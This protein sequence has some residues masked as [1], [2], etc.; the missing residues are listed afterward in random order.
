MPA[1]KTNK[2][3]SLFKAKTRVKHLASKATGKV[4]NAIFL[5][6]EKKAKERIRNRLIQQKRL[7]SFDDYAVRRHMLTKIKKGFKARINNTELNSKPW[8]FTRVKTFKSLN[9]AINN[10]SR[11][12]EKPELLNNREIQKI[13]QTVQA[14]KDLN[15]KEKQT[16]LKKM[17]RL[18]SSISR[19]NKWNKELNYLLD[20]KVK[21]ERGIYVPGD[22]KELNKRMDKT[23][24]FLNKALNERKRQK[25]GKK[26]REKLTETMA[27]R[28]SLE[29]LGLRI[30]AG[31]KEDLYKIKSLL[32]EWIKSNKG[33]IRESKDYV[34]NPKYYQDVSTEVPYRSIHVLYFLGEN[35]VPIEVHLR[36]WKMQKEIDKIDKIRKQKAGTRFTSGAQLRKN[37]LE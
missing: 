30:V 22:L 33:K 27:E 15:L 6:K 26:L 13:R 14:S 10:F 16:V 20:Y 19:I 17:N 4:F 12:C 35:K 37:H 28:I 21:M 32:D 8:F 1:K 2:V 29:A 9:D 34:R 3:S 25:L 23:R 7:F 36:T 24:R 11:K 5:V 18:E 31:T